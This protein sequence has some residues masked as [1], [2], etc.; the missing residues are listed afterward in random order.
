MSTNESQSYK[1]LLVNCFHPRDRVNRVENVLV[2]GMPDVNYCV[3][4]EE[5]WL[6]I[7]TPVATPIRRTTPVMGSAHAL[8]QEQCN[9]LLA[10]KRAGGLGYIY[11]DAPNRRYLI[12]GADA[13]K[14]NKASEQEMMMFCVW[15]CPVPTPAERWTELREAL[16]GH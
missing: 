16:C 3:A 9:W 5:G 6:E 12:D 13:D 8:S 15:S 11:V 1:T 4:G 14:V 10:Q 7:K 2:V